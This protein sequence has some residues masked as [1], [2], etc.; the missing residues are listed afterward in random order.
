[1]AP[2]ASWMSLRQQKQLYI[3]AYRISFA[4]KQATIAFSLRQLLQQL[5]Q[6]AVSV[7]RRSGVR[8]S[9]CLSVCLS[10][11]PSNRARSK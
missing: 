6:T 5:Q 10:V 9:M 8:T 7:K 11:C 3:G 4:L 1:M 2:P